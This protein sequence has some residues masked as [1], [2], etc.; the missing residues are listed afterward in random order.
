MSFSS[1]RLIL[2]NILLSIFILKIFIMI[3]YLD[4]FLVVGDL[5]SRICYYI[6]LFKSV[7]QLLN[8]II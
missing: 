4:I 6:F 7:W 5:L 1:R 2:N 3:F 8:Q